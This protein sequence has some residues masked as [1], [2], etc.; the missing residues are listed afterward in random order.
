[1]NALPEHYPRQMKQGEAVKKFVYCYD[2]YYLHSYL[3]VHS[4]SRTPHLTECITKSFAKTACTVKSIEA[5]IG[6]K[7][8]NGE[9]VFV[10]RERTIRY[11]DLSQS[12]LD[13]PSVLRRQEEA[14]ILFGNHIVEREQVK[15]HYKN[16]SSRLIASQGNIQYRVIFKG[17]VESQLNQSENKVSLKL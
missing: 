7:V 3:M 12:E 17:H 4:R 6:K 1:M 5:T 11:E 13:M 9:R 10:E 16:R 14:I 8:I 2:P 15:K